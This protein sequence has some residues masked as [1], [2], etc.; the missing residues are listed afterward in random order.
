MARLV[1][2]VSLSFF[3]FVRW[4][5]FSLRL[6]CACLQVTIE[7]VNPTVKSSVG[8]Y[9]PPWDL[10]RHMSGSVDVADESDEVGTYPPPLALASRLGP[11]QPRGSPE[12]QARG[13]HLPL[14]CTLS[15]A[16]SFCSG[17]IRKAL[18]RRWNTETR[19]ISSGGFLV[20]RRFDWHVSPERSPDQLQREQYQ[21][22]RDAEAF[23]QWLPLLRE[24]LLTGVVKLA[25][26]GSRGRP[27]HGGEALLPFIPFLGGG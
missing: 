21:V 17:V 5:W 22:L 11:T 26:F 7:A 19:G 12:R 18:Q 1:A 14:T 16:R 6:R 15:Q 24:D 9:P 2:G 3:F 13:S 23:Y 27:T 25:D 4:F 10:H 8:F 20:E